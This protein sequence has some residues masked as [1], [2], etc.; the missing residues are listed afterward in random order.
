MLKRNVFISIFSL[1]LLVGLSIAAS[2]QTKLPTQ[3]ELEKLPMEE[4]L[5]QIRREKFDIVL[6]D[7]MRNHNVDMWIHVMRDAIPDAFGQN[8]LGTASGLI[9][10]TDRGGSVSGMEFSKCITCIFRRKNNPAP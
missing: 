1:V 8:D 7:A 6:P 5:N 9:V 3:E 2:A 4:W 10:F